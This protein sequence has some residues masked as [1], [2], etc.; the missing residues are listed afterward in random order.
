MNVSATPT[1]QIIL[2]SKIPQFS[3]LHFAFSISCAAR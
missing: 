1:I 3:I 2:R